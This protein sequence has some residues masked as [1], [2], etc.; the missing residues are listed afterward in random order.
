MGENPLDQ[1]SPTPKGQGLSSLNSGGN[2]S[3]LAKQQREQHQ[4]EVKRGVSNRTPQSFLANEKMAAAFNHNRPG[5]KAAE[6]HKG[7]TTQ[8]GGQGG[9]SNI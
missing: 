6:V 7:M 8:S 5:V 2:N 4:Q 1:L 9:S 3:A